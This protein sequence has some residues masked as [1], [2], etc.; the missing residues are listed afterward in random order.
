MN[1]DV[2]ILTILCT[3][4]PAGALL[5]AAAWAWTRSHQ[6]PPKAATG[7]T[8]TGFRTIGE[9]GTTCYLPAPSDT[10]L[11]H[12]ELTWRDMQQGRDATRSPR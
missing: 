5:M 8:V 6:A 2:V 9:G 3:G 10:P 12:V 11:P 4:A 7:G 1:P